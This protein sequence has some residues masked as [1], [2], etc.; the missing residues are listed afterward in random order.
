MTGSYA[1]SSSF[2]I[3]EARYVGAKIGADL[4]LLN[5]YYGKPA[6]DSIDHYVEEVAFLLRDGYLDTVDY[7]FR[8]SVTHTWKLRLRYRATTG[9]QL[10]DSRPGSLPRAA[11]L[12]GYT[13]YSYLTYSTAYSALTTS[14]KDAVK[15]N[16]PFPRTTADAPSTPSGTTTTGNG[17]ARNGTGV[18]R[19]IYLAN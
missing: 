10:I 19:D 15:A 13:F 7:G 12:T 2:T 17:Y 5:N 11:E 3:T 6:L 1:R 16:L 4:R 18:S 8:D 14:E 9:G